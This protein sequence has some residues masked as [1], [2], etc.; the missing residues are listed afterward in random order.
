MRAW[1]KKKNDESLRFMCAKR[2]ERINEDI[3]GP[4]EKIKAAKQLVRLDLAD[5]DKNKN[6]KNSMD[7]GI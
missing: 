3:W 1:F 6:M 4:I 7:E 2:K 5:L